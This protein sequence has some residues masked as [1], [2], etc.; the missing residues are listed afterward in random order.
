MARSW[1]VLYLFPAGI[2]GF[3]PDGAPVTSPCPEVRLLAVAPSSRGQ[4]IGAA[5][6]EECVRRARA[7]GASVLALHTTDMMQSALRLYERMGFVRSPELDLHP[8]PDL[9]VKGY[10][11]NLEGLSQ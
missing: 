1:A 7:S 6:M 9:T 11:L 8:A 2:I 5:L 3:E 4:G 10:R